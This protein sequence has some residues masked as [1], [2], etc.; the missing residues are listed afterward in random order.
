MHRQLVDVG[1]HQGARGA[2]VR[3]VIFICS[4]NLRVV[5]AVVTIAVAVAVVVIVVVTAN[6][7]IPTVVILIIG[8][9]R[10]NTRCG[11]Y[12]SSRS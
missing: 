4:S 9:W 3:L 2:G 11:G 12:S 7:G 8:S 6:T 5:T 1:E 10:G